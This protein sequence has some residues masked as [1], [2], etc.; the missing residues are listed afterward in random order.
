MRIGMILRISTSF[1]TDIRVEKEARALCGAGFEVDVLCQRVSAG[2]ASRETLGYGLAIHRSDIQKDGPLRRALDSYRWALTGRLFVG[3]WVGPIRQFIDEFR[4]D[5]LHCHDLGMLPTVLAVADE[6]G[7][8]VVGDAHEHYPELR[9]V[10]EATTRPLRRLRL[11][12]IGNTAKWR[13]LEG[14]AFGRCR[15]VIVVGP[16]SARPF[17]E[18][19]GI[20]EGRIVVVRNT[21]DETTFR[22]GEPDPAIVERHAGA[23]AA[24][25][26][27]HVSPL[28]GIGSTAGPARSSD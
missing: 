25:Y 23:W 13:R 10:Y 1:P 15:R 17:I 22:V 26:V 19:H 4:P 8:A 7:L 2:E 28:R 6:R 18:H 3:S 12:L 9:A 27:G 21:E 24:T 16:E 5:V 14:E 11:K 20:H